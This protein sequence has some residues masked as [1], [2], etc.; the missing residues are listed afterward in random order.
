MGPRG[1]EGPPRLIALSALMRTRR[2]LKVRFCIYVLACAFRARQ[3]RVGV[4]AGLSQLALCRAGLARQP[5]GRSCQE[6]AL[7]EG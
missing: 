3:V 6:S 2:P 1:A 5:Y 4:R 7:R